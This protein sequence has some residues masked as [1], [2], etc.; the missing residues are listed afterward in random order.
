[1]SRQGGAAGLER[2]LLDLESRTGAGFVDRLRGLSGAEHFLLFAAAPGEGHR[3]ILSSEL[4]SSLLE[5][6]SRPLHPAED[7]LWFRLAG[8]VSLLEGDGMGEVPPLGSPPP[9]TRWALAAAGDGWA[10]CA[11]LLGTGEAPRDLADDPVLRSALLRR[12]AA[13]GAPAAD[14]AQA[15]VDALSRLSHEFK[16]PLVSIKGYAELILDRSDIPLTPRTR[17][18]VRRIAAG[19]NRLAGLFRKITEEGRTDWATAYTPQPVDPAR[20]VERCLS[21]AEAMAEGRDLSWSA[22]VPGGLP[23]VLLDPEAGR[24][25]LLELLQNAAR[26][27]P[28]GGR[29]VVSARVEEREGRPGV[30]LTVEDSGIG[31]PR[32]PAAEPLFE[33]FGSLGRLVE[34]HSG[35]FEFGAAGLGL[36]LSLVRGLARA[37]GGEAWAEGRGRDPAALP[38]ARFHVWIPTRGE[39]PE[40]ARAETGRGRVLVLD[41]D[42]EGGRILEEAL[43]GAYEIVRVRAAPEALRQWAAGSWVGCVVEPRLPEGGGVDLIQ[44]LRDTAG[45]G[46]PAIVAY[47]TAGALES[48]AWRLAGADACVAKPARARVLVQRLRSLAGRRSPPSR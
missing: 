47:S 43:Q 19:A 34:H 20:W 5:G 15:A 33:R 8:A 9:G 11:L 17:D 22:E 35:D 27:T 24:D 14:A 7:P 6:A 1:M 32:G 45:P 18:W 37:H 42:P 13:Q 39:T 36:G 12:L 44:A 31:I 29:V 25:L 23:P 46:G 40:A 21:E 3:L 38:G 4:P 2:G 41:P 48:S 26:A 30:R 10:F 16:T 28:D